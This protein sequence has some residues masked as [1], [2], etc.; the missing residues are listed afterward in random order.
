M[1]SACS[2]SQLRAIC[3]KTAISTNPMT[4][5][6][7]GGSHH[8][9][10]APETGLVLVRDRPQQGPDRDHRADAQR[11]Q[12]EGQPERPDERERGERRECRLDVRIGI[13]AAI[14][15]GTRG[16]SA[17]RERRS[18]AIRAATPTWPFTSVPT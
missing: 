11:R 17:G 10:P 3:A 13:S 4:R 12:P 2:I 7:P 18:A 8:G 15:V 14:R 1:P 6:R 16:L 9:D 5:F